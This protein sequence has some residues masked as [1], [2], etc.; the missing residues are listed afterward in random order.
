MFKTQ[1]GHIAVEGD[2]HGRRRHRQPAM[3]A[4]DDSDA[5]PATEDRAVGLG[6]GGVNYE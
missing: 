5:K 1:Q 6:V 3:G 2:E 4:A